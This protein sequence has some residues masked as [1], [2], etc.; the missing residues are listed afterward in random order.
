MKFTKP[1]I[2]ITD[3]LALLRRRGMVIADEAK[4]RHYLAYISYYRLR[5]YWIPFEGPAPVAGDHA[6]KPGTTFDDVLTLY[7]FD[8]HLRLLVLD[9][10]ER[11]EVALRAAWA[12]HVAMTHGPHGHIDPAHH[13]NPIFHANSLADYQK[14]IDRSND[15]FI[16]HYLRTYD[17]PAMPPVWMAAEIVSLGALSKWIGNMMA[18]QDRQAICKPFG[19]DEKVL[20]SFAHHISTVRNTAA[21][22][23]C[24]WNRR[25]TVKMTVPGYPAKLAIAM[26]GADERRLH[27][28][29]VMLDHL[30]GVVAPDSGWRGRLVAL[31]DGCPQA[32]PAAMGF[33]ADWRARAAW[34][35][36]A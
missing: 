16:S 25:F 14:E 28:T 4:A 30:L 32:D 29:L 21:H 34:R 6:F 26:R 17:D 2:S 18:R 35:V 10:I 36:V 31:I 22:H 11:V 12:H 23:G 20:V 8:R 19:V 24:L 9:A 13:L 15:L 7:L 3:Q 1:A 5:A 27:N 33:P